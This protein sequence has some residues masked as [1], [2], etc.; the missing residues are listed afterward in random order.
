[1]TGERTLNAVSYRIE[2]ICIVCLDSLEAFSFFLHFKCMVSNCKQQT[3]IKDYYSVLLL[4]SNEK[5][6]PTYK[7]EFKIATYD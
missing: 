6:L 5:C 2:Y 4:A 3:T 1:M 7:S